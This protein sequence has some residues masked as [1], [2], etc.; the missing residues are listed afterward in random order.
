MKYTFYAVAVI[1][2]YFCH[3][4]DRCEILK[5]A[6]LSYMSLFLYQI[7][8]HFTAEDS[9]LYI[10]KRVYACSSQ[11]CIYCLFN[12]YLMTWLSAKNNKLLC[13]SRLYKCYGWTWL[14]TLWLLWLWQQ[15][16]PHLISC[17][18]SHMDERNHSFLGQWWKIYW[19]RQYI[20]LLLSLPCCL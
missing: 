16:F 15:N 10:F 13:C 7:K 1:D 12:V 14:W 18:G 11:K 3:H 8:W 6:D 4:E 20:S 5:A 2:S 19:D 9:N 17:W